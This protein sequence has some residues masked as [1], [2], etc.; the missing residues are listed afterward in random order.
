M[1]GLRKG[2]ATVLSTTKLVVLVLLYSSV[3]SS[4]PNSHPL[5]FKNSRIDVDEVKTALTE[6]PDFCHNLECPEYKE[7]NKTKDY[8]EREYV[9][10]KWI[11]TH[12]EGV[13]YSEAIRTMFLKLFDYIDGKNSRNEKIAMTAPVLNRV[14]PGAGPACKSNF[15]MFFYL[16][17]SVTNPPEPNDKTVVLTSLPGQR[18]FT[19]YFGGFAKES[20]YVKNAEALGNALLKD[21]KNFDS[22]FF[23]TA[24]Y[25]SPFKILFRH[26][27]VWYVAK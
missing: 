19:R 20:D 11:S 8:E 13:D 6:K 14:I 17:P 15:T 4:L 18:V 26:N 9:P 10:T 7:I 24:G 1:Y 16:S 25:D 3:A 27:E 21:S 2:H 5:Y 22:S 12:L 23:Y